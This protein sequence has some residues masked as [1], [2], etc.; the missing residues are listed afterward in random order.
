VLGAECHIIA[1]KKDGP[2]GDDE[3]A[4]EKRDYF[5]NLILLCLACHKIIDDQPEKYTV[6]DLRQLK[7]DHEKWFRELS[8]RFDQA[9]QKDDEKYASIID[10]LAVRA[11]LDHWEEFSYL[12]LSQDQPRMTRQKDSAVEELR[13]WLFSRI[14]PGRY[15]A[16]EASVEN[17]R[18]VLSDFHEQFREHA[19]ENAGLLITEKFYRIKGW[20]AVRY[21]TL[22]DQYDHHVGMVQD[23]M[24]E[25]TRAANYVC[26]RYRETVSPRFRLKEGFV[27]ARQGMGSDGKEKLLRLTY[28]GGERTDKPYPGVVEFAEIRKQRDFYYGDSL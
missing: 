17:L 7:T 22:S 2:R 27:L 21:K 14:W 25:L 15:K 4:L 18:R 19:I 6:N 12:I 11:D 24:V 1:Q 5:D 3:L 28:R 13:A 20:D 9:K 16:L 8:G 10:E 23:L 26:E